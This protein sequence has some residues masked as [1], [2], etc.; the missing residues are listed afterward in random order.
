MFEFQIT[1]YFR[2]KHKLQIQISNYIKY[3]R[4][5]IG[6][7]TLGLKFSHELY[8]IFI[9]PPHPAAAQCFLQHSN[10]SRP[11]LKMQQDI[12]TPKQKCNAADLCPGQV[13]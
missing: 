3:T 8:F 6:P 7:L 5:R 13:W 10:M 11:R 2:H 9:N 1:K 4:I 12:R